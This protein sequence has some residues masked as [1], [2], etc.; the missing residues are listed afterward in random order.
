MSK[1]EAFVTFIWDDNYSFK[2]NTVPLTIRRTK[3]E[4]LVNLF[5]FPL[6]C[7]LNFVLLLPLRYIIFIGWNMYCYCLHQPYREKGFNGRKCN[8]CGCRWINTEWVL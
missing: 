7:I 1:N 3:A 5:Y 4:D 2:I 8:K 6:S